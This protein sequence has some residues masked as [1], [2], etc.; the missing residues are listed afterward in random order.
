MRYCRHCRVTLRGDLPTCP[1][2]DMEA[3]KIGDDFDE[4]YPYVKSRFSRALLLKL[5]SFIAVVF[6]ATGLL[7]NHLV[8]TDNP[9]AFITAGAI[10]YVWLSAISVLRSAP[11]PASMLLMQLF[12]VSGLTVLIDWLTGWYHWSITWVIPGL[13]V[14][15]AL[16]IMLMILISPYR[17]RAYTIYQLVIAVLGVLSF[18]LWVFGV[19]D[20]EWPIVTAACVSILCFIAMLVFSHRRTRVELAKR[21]HV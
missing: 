17:F 14:A 3:E 19:S 13:I 6:V 21:F 16:A 15:A 18:F 5:I 9:W 4:D 20:V 8:P 2:C 11:N 7:I 1:L 10:I 12:C